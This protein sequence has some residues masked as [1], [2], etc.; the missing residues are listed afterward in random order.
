[1][2]VKQIKMII[3]SD[4]KNVPLISIVVNRLCALTPFSS[5]TAFQIELCVVESI[6]NTIK[7][8][9]GNEPDRPVEVIFALHPN[10]LIFEICD[11]GKTMD[12]KYLPKKGAPFFEFDP[13]D[14]DNLPEGGMG[15]SIINEIM[16]QVVY[17]TADG[18][19]KLT[20]TKFFNANATK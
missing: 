5:I 4:F 2:H 20:L 18:I 16:D 15:L 17:T 9:Y 6:N 14:L 13:D 7:H 10:R 12:S 11:A 19:N 8:A 1:M 3:D